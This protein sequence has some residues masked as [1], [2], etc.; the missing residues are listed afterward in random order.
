MK[1]CYRTAFSAKNRAFLNQTGPSKPC[2]GPSQTNI[3]ALRPTKNP[4]R[5]TQ[6][7]PRPA[8]CSL[9]QMEI[10]HGLIEGRCSPSEYPL[11]TAQSMVIDQANKGS[12][13][14]ITGPS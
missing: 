2:K 8:E 1:Y 3:G 11:R 6:I 14:G 13:L 10:L 5:V 4:P 9:G 12:P 7:P